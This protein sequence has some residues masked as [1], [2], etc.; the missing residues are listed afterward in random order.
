[1]A[2]AAGEAGALLDA[3]ERVLGGVAEDGEDRGIAQHG[4]AVVAPE[5]GSDH[6]T[7][8]PQDHGE[9]PAVEGDRVVK[10]RKRGDLGTTDHA[11]ENG[12]ARMLWQAAQC[13]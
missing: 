3:V 8:K 4:D 13:L 11:D 6:A 7:V 10:A 2:L 5:P 1:M 12:R 9:F